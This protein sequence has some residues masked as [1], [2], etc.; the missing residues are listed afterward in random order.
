[1]NHFINKYTYEKYI[2]Q[3]YISAAQPA[4]T[5]LVFFLL[6]SVTP[7]CSSRL[8]FLTV[9]I[10][11]DCEGCHFRKMVISVYIVL[12]IFERYIDSWWLVG[13]TPVPTRD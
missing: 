11:C 10:L 3:Y 7:S 12:L 4:V 8:V 9:Y 13:T 2:L 6:F 5:H 1:M